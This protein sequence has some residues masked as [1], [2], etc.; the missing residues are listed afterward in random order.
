MHTIRRKKSPLEL[1]ELILKHNPSASI[2]MMTEL[3][4][5][6]GDVFYDR[7]FGAQESIDFESAA[8]SRQPQRHSLNV[9]FAQSVKQL[10]R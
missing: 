10:D 8:P 9:M 6:W 2:A 7:R 1:A 5:E 3:I 4:S